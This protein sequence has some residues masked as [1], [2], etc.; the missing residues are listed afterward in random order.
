M[1]ESAFPSGG[2]SQL[3]ANARQVLGSWFRLHSLERETAKLIAWPFR[4]RLA[5]RTL[6]APVLPASAGRLG[7]TLRI[8]GPAAVAAAAIA[9]AALIVVVV[10]RPAARRH[11]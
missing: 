4:M 11:L 9:I 1:R 3:R 2:A 8:A 5:D 10:T 6:S 7:V